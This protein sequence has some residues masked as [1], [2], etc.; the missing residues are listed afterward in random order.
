MNS[1]KRRDGTDG[2]R[3]PIGQRVPLWLVLPFMAGMLVAAAGFWG[4]RHKLGW[5]AYLA[6]PFFACG[7]VLIT[8]RTETTVMAGRR[9]VWQ[10]H[11]VLGWVP[12]GRRVVRAQQLAAVR[13]STFLRRDGSR[14]VPRPGTWSM[15]GWTVSLRLQSGQK[16]PVKTFFTRGKAGPPQEAEELFQHLTRELGVK[17]EICYEEPPAGF[18]VIR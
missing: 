9:E 18:S 2:I 11:F 16:H 8:L 17:G 14:P 7:A 12:V 3:N 6:S 5:P 13:L 15:H 4:L 10:R 1:S